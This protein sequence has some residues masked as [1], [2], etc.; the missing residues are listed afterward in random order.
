MDSSKISKELLSVIFRHETFARKGEVG[1]MIFTKLHDM[2]FREKR[3][4]PVL[5]LCA[6]ASIAAIAIIGSLWGLNSQFCANNQ[7]LRITLPDQSEVAL[8]A[9]SCLTYNRVMW[10]FGRNVSMR[11]NA[12]FKVSKGK[13]F[14]VKAELGE[15]NVLGTEFEVSSN[16]ETLLVECFEGA[17]EVKTSVGCQILHKGDMIKCTPTNVTFTPLPK[18]YT[19]H[20]AAVTAVFKEI[21]KT[22]GVT[23]SS[24]EKYEEILF[25][26]VIPTSNL[27]EALSVITLSCGLNYEIGDNHIITIT[28][29]E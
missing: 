27:S 11:G 29:Y 18:Y 3:R 16:N 13:Q 22:Y 5:S 2:R 14:T 1:Q 23:I 19:Y 12:R 28:D 25:D 6:A 17:V 9:G 8:G 20:H 24:K 10:L 26:G 4:S 21:E 15:I 7:A